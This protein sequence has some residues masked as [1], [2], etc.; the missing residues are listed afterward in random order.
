[1]DP[2]VL[3]RVIS[4]FFL[5]VRL[6]SY[7]FLMVGLGSIFFLMV[8]LRTNFFLMVGLGS[9]FF[10]KVGSGFGPLKTTRSESGFFLTI[11]SRDVTGSVFLKVGSGSTSSGSAT[12]DKTHPLHAGPNPVLEQI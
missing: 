5:M 12:L 7:F 1:M 4:V 11:E 2:G 3:S 8:G 6:G 10:L 9:N